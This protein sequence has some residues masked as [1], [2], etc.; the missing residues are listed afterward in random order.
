MC[1]T[2]R[3]SPGAHCFSL[4]QVRFFWKA[5][6]SGSHHN[7]ILCQLLTPSLRFGG[8]KCARLSAPF[9]GPTFLLCCK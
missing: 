4:P 7:F 6:T 9:Q 8:S 2:I 3:P 5:P 1:S